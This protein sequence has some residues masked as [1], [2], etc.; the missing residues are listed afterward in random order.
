MISGPNG[1]GKTTLAMDVA[2]GTRK[3]SKTPGNH[4]LLLQLVHVLCS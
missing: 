1:I 3:W 4:V 2:L